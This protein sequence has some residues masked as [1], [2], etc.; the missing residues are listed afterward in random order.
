MSNE[1]LGHAIGHCL[2]DLNGLSAAYLPDSVS[3]ATARAI[4]ESANR[5]RQVTPPFSILVAVGPE[6][7][8]S[9]ASLRLSPQN[10]IRYRQDD[11]LAVVIGR[12]PDLASF[13]QAFREVLG[14]SYP[15]GASGVIG[16]D[17]IARFALK[18]ILHIAGASPEPSWNRLDVE[19]RIA[20]CLLHVR[21]AYEELRQ[22]SRGWNAYWFDHVTKAF[23]NLA[24]NLGAAIDSGR[25]QT[26][27]DFFSCFTYASFALPTPKV[28][29]HLSIPNGKIGKAIADTLANWWSD[30]QTIRISIQQ[31]AH[32]PDTLPESEHPLS[33]INWDHFDRVLADK[34]NQMLAMLDYVSTEQN[35]LRYAALTERQFF[36]PFRRGQEI[37]QLAIFGEEGEDV[38]AATNPNVG[39]FVLQT[40][41][42]DS[43]T[44]E[45]EI[46][47]ISVPLTALPTKE[48]VLRSGLSLICSA[49]KVSWSG[50]LDLRGETLWFIGSFT[51]D[52]GS[53]TYSKPVITSN[54]RLLLSADDSLAGCVDPSSS[55][56]LHLLPHQGSGL[57]FMRANARGQLG[58]AT[59]VGE[60][61]VHPTALSD[62]T[63]YAATFDDAVSRYQVVVWGDDKHGARLESTSMPRLKKRA[64][65]WAEVLRPRGLDAFETGLS[66]F[67][68]RSP[69]SKTACHSPV[70]A[71][72]DNQLVSGE[73]PS[74]DT[75]RSVR[76]VLESQLSDNLL[77]EEWRLALGHIM[78]PADLDIP[79]GRLAVHDSAVLMND[80]MHGY[81]SATTGFTLLESF[82]HSAAAVNFRQAF[83]DLG[84]SAALDPGADSATR[85]EWPSRTSWRH[86]WSTNREALDSYLEAYS[87]L[88][89]CARETSDASTIFWATYPFS[90]SI[91]DAKTSGKCVAVMLSPLH[92]L[93]LS[94]L[95][96]VE[97]TLWD[98]PDAPDLAGTL[99]G[100]N[101]P[102]LGP[103]ETL[104][105]RMVAIPTDNGEG[106]IFLGWSMLVAASID[107]ELP[108][109]APIKV[110]NLNAPGS[111]ASG[112]NATAAA[113][114]LRTYKKMHPHVSTLT[115]DLA[116]NTETSRLD[117][118]DE[119]VLAAVDEWT[120][121]TDARLRGGARIWD[122]LNRGG[123]SPREAVNKLARNAVGSPITWAR[124]KT[125]PMESKRANVRMLQDSGIRI[126]I[127]TGDRQNLGLLG[128]VP[129]R[130]FEAYEPP[131]QISTSSES[132]PGLRALN[133]W[134]AFSEA[135]AAAEN[136]SV[137]PRITSK[138]FNTALVDDRADWTVS[139][140]ALMS[141]SAMAS[142]VKGSTAGSQMLWEWRPPF[143]EATEGVPV[144]ERRP[145]VS[146]ARVPGSFREQIRSMLDK[147][148]DRPAS[149]DD[150]TTLLGT[151]GARGVGLSSLISMGGT[152][153][154]GALGFYLTFS[155]MESSDSA[156]TEEFVL[157]I[158]ACDSFLK[159]LAGKS[160]HGEATRRADLLVVRL[161]ERGITLTPIEIKFHGFLGPDVDARLP[162]PNDSDF[163]EPL[164]QLSATYE[165]L[166]KIQ[167]RWKDLRRGNPSSRALWLNGLTALVEAGARLRP[168]GAKGS[169]GLHDFMTNL[170]NG[171]MPIRIGRPIVTYFRHKST[172]AT[173]EAYEVHEA[174]K[175]NTHDVLGQFGSLAS[176]VAAAFNESNDRQ[177]DLVAKWR[178]LIAWSADNATVDLSSDQ[179][180]AT[181][182]SAPLSQVVDPLASPLDEELG[183]EE[184]SSEGPVELVVQASEKESADDSVFE[185]AEV[186]LYSRGHLDTGE[187]D[188][189]T[190]LD[191]VK[192]QDGVRF[193]VGRV[194]NTAGD[195]SAEFWPSNTA[196]NQMNVGVV[197]DL[198]TGKTQLLKSLIYNLRTQ[199]SASQTN[200]LSILIFDYKRDFQDPSFLNS[201]GGV[202]LR[203]Q[204]IP[205]NIFAL[206]DGYSPLA[207]FQKAKAFCDVI[208]K[209]YAGVGPVQKDRLVTVITQLFKNQDGRPPTLAQIGEAYREGIKADSVVGTLNTFVLGE[210]F[211]EDPSQLVNF[212]DLIQ[213]RV[214][215]LAVNEL[216]A[217]QDSKN[218]LVAL[219]LNMYYEYMLKAEKW[220]Y[221]GASPQLRKLNSFLLVDE[222]VNIMRYEFPALMDIMLQGREFGVGT[223]LASQ[224]LSHFRTSGVNY[225][226]PLL[227]WFIHKVPNVTLKELEQLGISGQSGDT[228]AHIGE[229]EV[230]E[231]LYSSLGFRGSFIRGTPF[232]Q[233][234]QNNEPEA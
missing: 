196:L 173:N 79:M 86:L 153:A 223:I 37:R 138:L 106:Q 158:D 224:Y 112:L 214:L 7:V 4:V 141:P 146:V 215:V 92:P 110:G 185:L 171:A 29:L 44:I 2:A 48:Q 163:N 225:G 187:S 155:L 47:R 136:S 11:R 151:L 202:V 31:L 80:E 184:P 165:L 161:E 76:G 200:P 109:A 128:S 203:P 142:L 28:E 82:V 216:G 104:N 45:S 211:G 149:D 221:T 51:R 27:D 40:S 170:V 126:E 56:T 229:Q 50:S 41:L 32:H 89:R 98:A 121:A 199:A 119:A 206:P 16:F 135:L 172:T 181:S 87:E 36:D 154:A 67:E 33:A 178:A 49:P 227:T 20:F 23:D 148:Y 88:V 145:F 189:T 192:N 143:L 159:A 26:L 85:G 102:L 122:S 91:W 74:L 90:A 97:S 38:S 61:S 167:N 77:N 147:A 35:M 59:Y 63:T 46:V 123:E 17:S 107:G 10:A 24:T 19:T 105:G 233:I 133:G 131:T 21:D 12:H 1:I 15:A 57:M 210:V 140:E 3:E 169:E 84:I 232:Y 230:H 234:M 130:R 207:A 137:K 226:E 42:Q 99:E 197:G 73:R 30:E 64:G 72:V 222:A 156:G 69:E 213:N 204:N 228:A 219:F 125:D 117:E 164:L 191:Y 198:G 194:L 25:G 150:V 139:G 22:G 58:R 193:S 174:Q 52:T 96:S 124:Y 205:L 53:M 220:P 39:P 190:S 175:S 103:R 9:Q 201:V 144:L 118:V 95:A 60:E 75:E 208:G 188:P 120:R 14:Q 68:I 152:H 183:G 71:A 111:A 162:A 160:R 114:A 186:A 100:W 54:L 94:W 129:L 115:I 168:A 113:A 8:E 218:A 179:T 18:E 65:I 176:N 70:V 157:P 62:Q 93:R 209:I 43:H 116:A 55:C 83:I 5:R 180:S 134:S 127:G 13:V 108:L 6:E 182:P 166:I 34:D 195:F 212:E 177:S 217:D 132:R 78:L 101:F 66:L 81:W 231:A